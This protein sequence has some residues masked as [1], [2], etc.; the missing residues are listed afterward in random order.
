[1]RSHHVLPACAAIVAAGLSLTAPAGAQTRQPATGGLITDSGG[2]V[3]TL[4]AN[5]VAGPTFP[6]AS[7]LG[8]VAY[9]TGSIRRADAKVHFSSPDDGLGFALYETGVLRAGVVARY[10]Q[11]R[12][13]SDDRRLFG[14]RDAKWAIEPGVF[15]EI[16]A[17]PETL[18]ARF[19]LRRGFHGHEGVVGNFGLD[20]VQRLGSWTFS[21]GPRVAFAD[22]EY[23][24]SYFGVTAQ[25]AAWNPRV[26]PYKPNGGVKGY[27][28]AG[29]ITYKFNESWS[30][31]GYASYERLAKPAADSPIVKSFGKRDQVGFGATLSYSFLWR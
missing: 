2:W 11:G 25:D 30:A 18:R 12:Y 16:W 17:V 26:A 9:P 15:A 6:G 24:K 21:A 8:F 20:L 14:I 22:A 3:V 28:A 7:D 5:A 13:L 1:M 23:M 31:T 4:R 19:E 27:G 29:A 10:Q